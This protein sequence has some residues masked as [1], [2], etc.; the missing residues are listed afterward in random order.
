MSDITARNREHFDQVASSHL[1]DWEP[2]IQSVIEELRD[3]RS[4][5]SGKLGDDKASKNDTGPIKLLDYACGS[6]TVSK[7]PPYVDETVGVDLSDNMVA[8]YNKWA[9][10]Q[11][12]SYAK[13]HALQL[14]LLAEPQSTDPALSDFDVAVVCMALHHVANPEALLCR[15]SKTLRPGGVCVVFDRV[16]SDERPELRADLPEQATKVLQTISKHGFTE[17]DMRKYFEGAGMAKNFEHAVIA[18]PFKLTMFGQEMELKG[19]IARGEVA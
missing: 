19:F 3:R 18:R 16:F 1:N 13:A 11:G 17:E 12:F 14:D 5:I 15:L 6:G 2:L 7:A 4:W 9:Q 8:E 10:G